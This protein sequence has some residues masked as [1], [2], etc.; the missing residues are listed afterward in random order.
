VRF[1]AQQIQ[2]HYLHVVLAPYWDPEYGFRQF[3]AS[4]A[5]QV[6]AARPTSLLAHDSLVL[7][8]SSYRSAAVSYVHYLSRDSLATAAEFATQYHQAR[9]ALRGRTRDY[10]WFF[11]LKQHREQ[12]PAA[13]A[14]CYAQF[15]RE[16]TTQAYVR[17]LDSLVARPHALQQRPDLLRTPLLSST[18]DTLTWGQLVARNHGQPTYLD[19][20]ASWCIPCLAEMPASDT[21]QA[22][23][24]GRDVHFV[25]LS[26]DKDKAAW[27]RAIQRQGLQ[28]PGRQH[29]LLDPHSA[30]ATFLNVPPI[31]R[32]VLLDK[33]GRAVSLEAP[34]PSEARLAEALEKLRAAP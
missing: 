4:Y 29:Y 24:A 17:Y 1:A 22:S 8:S 20:W 21:L 27:L 15:R 32:Y 10:V 19:L 23:P 2:L 31:P 16:C 26:I 25:Y 30:L 14:A 33:Q 9:T 5:D 13:Y 28:R 7:V 12:P 6:A 11:L 3:P 18:G 34:R